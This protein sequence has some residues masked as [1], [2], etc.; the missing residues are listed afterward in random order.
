M[1][2]YIPRS[3]QPRAIAGM[4]AD[5]AKTDTISAFSGES[6]ATIAFGLGLVNPGSERVAKLPAASTDI[7]MGVSA[8]DLDHQPDTGA[9]DLVSGLAGGILPKGDLKVLRKG[10]LFVVVDPSVNSITPFKDRGFVRYATN[11]GNTTI[12][13]FSNVTDALKNLD[14]TKCVQFL[15][16]VI[17]APDGVTKIALAE[18]QAD[19]LP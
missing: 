16:D 10:R 4:I 12:G 7:F 11:G 19:V 17:L 15:S 3:G 9:L 14:V 1:Q 5:S 6:S 8:W 13:A 2:T 18:I